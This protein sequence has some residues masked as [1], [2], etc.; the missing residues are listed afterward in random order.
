M[1]SLSGVEEKAAA[2]TVSL[3][4]PGDNPDPELQLSPNEKD[5]ESS[6]YSSSE[7]G[8]NSAEDDA[9]DACEEG[10][11]GYRKG[12]YHPISIGDLFHSRYRIEKKL[13]WGHFSTVWL[14]I[15]E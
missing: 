12:G 9:S 7:A 13:G 3:S 4:V 15:D 5:I 8:S 6:R 10:I 1:I 11:G 2:D 14:A